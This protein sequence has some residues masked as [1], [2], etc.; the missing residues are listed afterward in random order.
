[1]NIPSSKRLPPNP[2]V[3]IIRFSSLGDVVKCTGLPRQIKAAY[4]DARITFL[5]SDS[6]LP[7]IADHPHLD[8]AIGFHRR[9][10]A[11]GLWRL[12]R[13]LKREKFDLVVDVHRSPRS[14]LLGWWLGAPRT[15][16]SKR[17]WQRLLLIQWGI[18]TYRQPPGKEADFLAAVAPWGVADDGLGTYIHLAPLDRKGRLSQKFAAELSV[19]DGWRSQ[20]VPVAG[21]APVAAWDL[22][23][24]PPAHVR[25]WMEGFIR[26]TGGG[27]VLFGGPGDKD[28][29]P[30]AQG[31][32]RHVLVLAGKTSLLESA[33]FA[34]KTDVCVANDT[35]M[36][37]IAEA[38]G[39]DVV[40]LFGPTSRELGYF[41]VRPT[42]RVVELPLRCRPCSRNGGGR[43]RHPVE[44]ACLEWITPAMVLEA[45]EQTLQSGPKPQPT[46]AQSTP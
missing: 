8:S 25:G 1:M 9:E 34:A 14:R 29:P 24:W 11:T 40:A 7:I 13:R 41:P 12:A 44:K 36:S 43:C 26:R 15:A 31:L 33:W 20:G 19:L 16:Y 32:E 23:R 38:V 17:T 46:P 3:L 42:S 30:L 2:R 18:N 4:P 5:T 37:H 45:V 27:I 35:G 6:F 21:L 39:R 28:L 10:G 22:K